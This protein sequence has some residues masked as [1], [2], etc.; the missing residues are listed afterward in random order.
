MYHH[1]IF[2]SVKVHTQ[3]VIK[4]SC[5]DSLTVILV[6]HLLHQWMREEVKLYMHLW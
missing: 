3:K 2:T 4:C 6:S 5:G 1:Q